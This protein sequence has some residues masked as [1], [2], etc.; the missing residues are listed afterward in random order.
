MKFL[1]IL[2]HFEKIKCGRRALPERFGALVSSRVWH[3]VFLRLKHMPSACLR[4]PFSQRIFSLTA[5]KG[6]LKSSDP[7]TCM[8]R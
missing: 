1:G 6:Y 8:L 4:E 2:P 7:D 3:K 5:K